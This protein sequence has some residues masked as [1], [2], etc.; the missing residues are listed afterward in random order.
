MGADKGV[1]FMAHD[2]GAKAYVQS[3]GLGLHEEFKQ[4]GVYV[5]VLPPGPTDTP[6]LAKFGL[7]SKTMPIKPMQVDQ[8]VAEGLNA[9]ATDRAIIIPGRMNLIMRAIVPATLTRSMMMKMFEKKLA[10]TSPRPRLG[11]P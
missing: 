7:D 2:T 4:R 8:V 6:V 11:R 10:I 5:T 9:L 1:A 3:L